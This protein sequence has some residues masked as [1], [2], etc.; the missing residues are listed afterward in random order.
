MDDR[1]MENNF[2]FQIME[3]LKGNE[4]KSLQYIMERIGEQFSCSSVAF[5]D[6][7]GYQN[8]YYKI[9]EWYGTECDREC[10]CNKLEYDMDAASTEEQAQTALVDITEQKE[11]L[12]PGQD[13]SGT[14]YGYPIKKEEKSIG[15]VLIACRSS[16]DLENRKL[17]EIVLYMVMERYATE[18]NMEDLRTQNSYLQ[19]LYSKI[20]T[21]LIQCVLENDTLHMIRANDV[22]FQIYGC[23]REEYF[24]I[25]GYSMERFI[26]VE[27]WP[28]VLEHLK[29]LLDGEDIREY[30]HRYINYFGQMR[31][32]HVNALRIINQEQEEVLQLV[33]SDITRAKQLENDLEHEKERYR[34]A[35]DSSSDVIFEYDLLN[36]SYISYGSFG[37]H[38]FPKTTP[39]RTRGFLKKLRNGQLCQREHVERYVRFMTGE[40]T[41][42]VEIRERYEEDGKEN[43]IWVVIEG[44]PIYDNG[45]LIK[46]I[47][48]KTNI[49]EKKEKEKAAL[50]VVQRDRLTKLYTRNVGEN[51]IQKYLTEKS[52]EEEGTLI[53]LDID[54][55]QKI[56]DTYGYMFGDA[57]LEEV[58]EVIKA[59]TR[60]HDI[61]VRYGGDEFL[62]VMKNTEEGKTATYGRRIYEKIGS[63]YVGEKENITIS[64]SVGMVSTKMAKDYF[65]LFQYADGM[66]AYVKNHGKNDTLCY[67]PAGKAAFEMQGEPYIEGADTEIDEIVSEKDNEDIVSFAFSILEQ[68]KDMRSAINLL[69]GKV[70]RK[71]KLNKISI[72]ESDANFLSNII[73]YEWTAK[74]EFHDSICKY[75]ISQDERTLWISLF[76]SEGLFV[77]KDEWRADFTDGIKLEGN[78]PRVRN[79]LYSAIYEEGEFKGT[80]VFEHSDD[81]YKWPK[82]IRTKLKEVSKIISTHITKANADIASKAKTEFLSRMSHEIRT[83]MNAIMGMATIAQSVIGDDK[84]VAECLGKI[85]T[86]TNYLLSLIND[87]LD[88]SRI[89]SGSMKVCL[90]PFNLDAL[91]D[92]IV[93]LMSAQ[94]ENKTI[95][96]EVKRNYQD[97]L[98]M[99]DELRLNQVLINIVGNA[100]KF[101]PEHGSITISVE[102]VMQE[103][104][105]ATIRFSVKD[106]GIGINENNLSRIF[107]AFEQAENN[108]A[109]RFGGTGL[110]LAI[111]SNLVK[112]MGGKLD[113]RSEEGKGSEFFFS[114]AFDVAEEAPQN[115]VVEEKQEEEYHLEGNRLLV[116][117]DNPINAEIAQ[118]VLEMEGVKSEHAGN[119]EEAIQMFESREEGYY[120][121]ILMDIRMPVMDGLE[122]T[123][124]I[125]TLGRTDS[126]TIP[127]IA[128][129]ANA[130]DED[131]KKSIDSG[132]NGHL[133]KPIDI[134]KL[135]KV[136]QEIIGKK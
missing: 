110:G 79:Q 115:N 31:W 83:P 55:F 103:E 20:Q 119:G 8:V 112:L 93:V 74:K 22:A 70:G 12:L 116:V 122:A 134:E 101:T 49:N 88:M 38:A 51:L 32:L 36:D 104:G 61:A 94:A 45:I 64:C 11:Q 107:N 41:E 126:R 40:N 62:I 44:T 35:L 102:Q 135:Y 76:D 13:M 19:T 82:E 92:E 54:N 128:M 29:T 121:A 21:G 57:I 52:E 118:T 33:I 15:I 2:L 86:S 10:F 71:L 81:K 99:G 98:L 50:E 136:L 24:S 100:L 95:T 90:E 59:T 113:V 30:E 14:L 25:Y 3:I 72:I 129:T 108:T 68:T 46:I 130:F 60:Q 48:K 91:V 18:K 58:A 23:S 75:E 89:E 9:Y 114:I 1:T 39:I 84:K 53:L 5:F 111:S 97:R 131:M 96:L 7:Q 85:Q 65:T 123:K 16:L 66:L 63:L 6:Y 27:D 127:I 106:T 124:R 78:A 125:R 77:M 73:T 87:I 67:S 17:L 43:Y 56:N 117:E 37:K 120:D 69:L 105:I 28:M 47:G 133:S 34:I 80:V 109:R 26:Y 132:M 4:Q 42:P